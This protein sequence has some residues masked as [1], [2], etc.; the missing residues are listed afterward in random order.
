MKNHSN[1]RKETIKFNKR[2]DGTYSMD[3]VFDANFECLITVYLCAT[4]CRSA[5]SIPL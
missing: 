5:L 2:T 4:E 3:L 1:I